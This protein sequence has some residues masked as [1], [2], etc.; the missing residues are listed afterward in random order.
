M[1]TSSEKEIS[2][3]VNLQALFLQKAFLEMNVK[4][5]KG[6]N[7]NPRIIQYHKVTSLGAS[8]D[9]IPWCSSFANFIVKRCGVEGTGS[10]MARSWENWGESLDKPIP[11]CL[12]V[13]KRGDNP[14]YGHVTFFLYETK[15]NIYCLGG[16]QG[17]SVAISS[18]SKSRV[19]CYRA[20]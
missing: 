20:A 12:V 1:T 16:N 2:L 17:D 18:Y 19:V 15:K 13:L 14:L 3:E 10:A 6:K 11:G 8:T 5:V 4:E 7:H 9:E